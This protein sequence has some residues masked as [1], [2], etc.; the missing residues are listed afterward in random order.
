MRFLDYCVVAVGLS[1]S[2]IGSP[3][4]G[5]VTFFQ[6]VAILACYGMNK[7]LNFLKC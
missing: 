3:H 7:F 5:E 6:A 4:A 1:L 2:N